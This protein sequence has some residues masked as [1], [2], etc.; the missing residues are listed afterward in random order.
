MIPFLLTLPRLT[1]NR[2]RE[3]KRSKDSEGASYPKGYFLRTV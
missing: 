3:L 2:S 1:L